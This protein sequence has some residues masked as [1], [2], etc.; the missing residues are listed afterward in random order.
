MSAILIEL[1]G[2]GE[3]LRRVGQALTAVQNPQELMEAIGSR[4]RANVEH[5]FETKTDPDGKPWAPLADISPL[6]YWT[7][8]RQRRASLKK[9]ADGAYVLPPMPGSLLERTNH[10]LESLTMN[11]TVDTM[12]LGFTR[13]YAIYHETGTKRNDKPYMPRRGMLF[14]DPVAKRLGDQDRQDVLDEL[15]DFLGAALG[16]R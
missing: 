6:L 8:D 2:E 9:D 7:I 10:M 11:S 5:R 1:E 12:E 15:E 13:P 14:G 3:L 4:L 16:Q